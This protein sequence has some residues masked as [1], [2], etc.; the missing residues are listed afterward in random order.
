MVVTSLISRT[1]E[2][3]DYGPSGHILRTNQVA[4]DCFILPSG[5]LHISQITIGKKQIW[6]IDLLRICP[7]PQLSD[8]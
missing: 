4:F 7:G 1:L 2:Y 8:F 5:L 6:F 3:T